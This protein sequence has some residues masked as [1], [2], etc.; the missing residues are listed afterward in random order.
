MMVEGK[1]IVYG[2]HM[3]GFSVEAAKMTLNGGGRRL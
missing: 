1:V 2:Y 3:R